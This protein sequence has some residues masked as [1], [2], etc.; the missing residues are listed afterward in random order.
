VLA[1]VLADEPLV[2]PGLV[3]VEWSAA[4]GPPGAPQYIAPLH[5]HHR[6]DEAWYVLTGALRFRLGDEDV[7][8]SA[9]GAMIAPRGTP[10]TYWN[11]GRVPARYVLVLTPNLHRLIEALHSGSADMDAVWRAY[12]SESFGWP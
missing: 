3:L 9:G 2:G 11:P 6:D 10:H 12:D 5:V 8:A 1:P 4:P 7:E